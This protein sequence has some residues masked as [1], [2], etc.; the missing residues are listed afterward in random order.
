MDK[1]NKIAIVVYTLSS[2]GLERVV[3]N[4]TFLFSKMG[5]Q[6]SLFVLENNVAYDFEA[7]FYTYDF[8]KDD[9]LIVFF[10]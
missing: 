4:Q 2:G 7:K 5:Y 6:V 3:A 8:K 9:L 1:K 10:T